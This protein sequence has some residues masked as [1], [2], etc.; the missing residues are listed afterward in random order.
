MG[1][2]MPNSSFRWLAILANDK[3]ECDLNH[4]VMNAEIDAKSISIQ[5]ENRANYRMVDKSLR[6]P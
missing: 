1:S 5:A 6:G 4:S 3:R 2:W